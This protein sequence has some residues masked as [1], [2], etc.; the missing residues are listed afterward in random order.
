M[1][2]KLSRE[3]TFDYGD[4]ITVEIDSDKRSVSKRELIERYSLE[5]KSPSEIVRLTGATYNY[6]QRIRTEM[7]RR[8]IL[9]EGQP[10]RAL[11]NP[12]SLR[13]KAFAYF[14]QGK[15]YSEV[16]KIMGFRYRSSKYHL[17]KHYFYEWKAMRDEE[18][19]EGR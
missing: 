18:E 8:G 9:P 1:W 13:Q 5:G 17:V 10:F 12:N 11:P 16:C 2:F 4:S 6:V 15:T 3:I 14:D 7:R 19:S